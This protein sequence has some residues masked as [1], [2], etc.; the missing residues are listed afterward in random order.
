M[1]HNHPTEGGIPILEAPEAQAD[2]L[3][4]GYY[5][6]RDMLDPRMLKELNYAIDYVQRYNHGTDGHL[7]KHTAAKMA[8]L[9]DMFDEGIREAVAEERARQQ[10]ENP[11]IVVASA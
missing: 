1:D 9:L 11:K 5:P 3:P 8:E 7:L 4:E 6:W 2:D 10:A